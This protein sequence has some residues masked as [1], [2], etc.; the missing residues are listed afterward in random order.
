MGKTEKTVLAEVVR[1]HQRI[2]VNRRLC[3]TGLLVFSKDCAKRVISI[4]L[5]K[6]HEI[7]IFIHFTSEKPE[8]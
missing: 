2:R 4:I 6:P 3:L 5:F 7:G 8:V 1:E